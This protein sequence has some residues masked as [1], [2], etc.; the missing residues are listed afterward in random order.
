MIRPF[1]LGIF[2][3]NQLRCCDIAFA[4]AGA[5]GAGGGHK[6][7][8]REKKGLTVTIATPSEAKGS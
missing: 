7:R 6:K 2:K 5:L 8:D 3:T 1:L 4:I